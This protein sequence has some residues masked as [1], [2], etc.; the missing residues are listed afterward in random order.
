MTLATTGVFPLTQEAGVSNLATGV[1]T[2]DG[3]GAIIVYIGFTPRHVK[4][5]DVTDV[6]MTEWWDT[7]PATNSVLSATN[8]GM[9]VDTNSLV[10]SNGAILSITEVAIQGTP[11][12]AGIGEGTQGTV[13]FNIEAPNQ[14]LPRC[15]FGAGLNVNAKV[16]S[17]YA[18]G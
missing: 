11:G 2:G 14:S 10:V 6:T 4:V 8:G 12:Q 9:T 7:L 1:Y 16:Y 5:F 18:E 13:T 3:S 17:W 15:T